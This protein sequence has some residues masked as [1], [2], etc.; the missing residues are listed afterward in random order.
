MINS[1]KMKLAA[2]IQSSL[3]PLLQVNKLSQMVLYNLTLLG[4]DQRP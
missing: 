1:I 4:L 2:K 3:D